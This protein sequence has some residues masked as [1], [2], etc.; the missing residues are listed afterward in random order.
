[1]E[2]Q[3]GR[4]NGLEFLYEIRTYGDLSQIPVIILSSV[5]PQ[6]VQATVAYEFLNISDYLYKPTTK[7]TRVVSVVNDCVGVSASQSES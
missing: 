5:D 4:H 6:F 7:L 1:M 3:L 2:L